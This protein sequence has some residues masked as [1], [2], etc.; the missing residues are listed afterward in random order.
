M[1]AFRVY[2][3]NSAVDGFEQCISKFDI[4][5]ESIGINPEDDAVFFICEVVGFSQSIGGVIAAVLC[6]YIGEIQ[7]LFFLIVQG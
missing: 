5:Y 3:D 1:K 4:R 6:L 2:G 7:F